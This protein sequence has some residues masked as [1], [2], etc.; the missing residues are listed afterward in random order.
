MIKVNIA[1]LVNNLIVD[2]DVI[3]DA[4]KVLY[5]VINRDD[6][7]IDDLEELLRFF[8]A[9]VDGYHHVKEERILFP[10]LNLALFP[11]EGSPVYVM[12]SE[13]GIARYLI[14]ISEELLAR[15]KGGDG[16]A[17]NALMDYLR[18]LADHLDQHIKKENDVLF[19]SSLAL[20]ETRSSRS[21]E[22]IEKGANHSYW[23]S[24]VNELKNKYGVK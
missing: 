7:D 18:L 16:N 22:D 24:R 6:I 10:A 20:D 5:R 21:V 12:V 2:H 9:F 11:F 19:P 4:I 13:H 17:R 23:V 3:L 14:R 15:F 1:G 8:E